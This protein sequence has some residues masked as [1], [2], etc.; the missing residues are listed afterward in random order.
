M[1]STRAHMKIPAQNNAGTNMAILKFVGR[2]VTALVLL[3]SAAW[4]LAIWQANRDAEPV[5]LA[6]RQA[7]WQRAVGWFK[8][9]EPGIL[10]DGNSALWWMVQTAAERSQDAYLLALVQESARRVYPADRPALPWKRMVDAKAEVT[11]VEFS[12]IEPMDDYQRFFL[13]ALGCKALP[14]DSGGDTSRFLKENMCRPLLGKVW[15]G[16]PVCSTHHAMGLALFKRTGCPV[17][18][19]AAQTSKQVQS[20]IAFQTT[21]DILMRDAYMQHVLMLMWQGGPDAIKPI[22]LRRVLNEQQ[23]DGGWLGRK[24]YPFL[25]DALQ[26]WGM[27]RLLKQWWPSRFPPTIDPLDFHAS[28]QGLLLTALSLPE[29]PRQANGAVAH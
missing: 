19:E 5:P 4:A 14:L 11:S 6:E 12:D 18:P 24:H 3:L 2:M 13:H 21:F 28:A 1:E 20:D 7:H 10:S 22:W 9:N 27:H 23:P 16:D 25:P 15:P 26:T 8:A 17:P 29:Q